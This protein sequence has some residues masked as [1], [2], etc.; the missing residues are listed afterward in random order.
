[1]LLYAGEY[2]CSVDSQVGQWEMLFKVSPTTARQ[3]VGEKQGYLQDR[4]EQFMNK[5]FILIPR[6]EYDDHYQEKMEE[7]KYVRNGPWHRVMCNIGTMGLYNHDGRYW[8]IRRV[9]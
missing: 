4:Y 6:D 9:E 3:I 8:I 1:M 7:L 5:C 2:P